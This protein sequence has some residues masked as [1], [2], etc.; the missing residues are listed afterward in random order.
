MTME[1]KAGITPPQTAEDYERNA[2]LHYARHDQ[3][4]A[5]ADFRKALEMNASLV[6]A[7]YGLGMT[8][9]ASGNHD[10]ARG[11]FQGV[12]GLLDEG[13]VKDEARA[14]ILR[15]LTI[16]QLGFLTPA[17]AEAA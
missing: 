14:K 13:S 4:Q 7:A 12:I 3:T 9:K 8:L 2:W 15:A 11:A 17:A 16:A 6:D 10:Q 1:G 5:E